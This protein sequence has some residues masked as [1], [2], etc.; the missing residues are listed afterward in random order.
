MGGERATCVVRMRRAVPLVV[1]V[2]A[3]L[4]V[5]GCG[6]ID[7]GP[8]PEHTCPPYCHANR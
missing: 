3:S 6:H 1:A 5:A 7:V 2:L 8:V 4:V